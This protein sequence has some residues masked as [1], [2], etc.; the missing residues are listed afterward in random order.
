[1]RTI[2]YFSQNIDKSIFKYINSNLLI[3]ETHHL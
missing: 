1:M 3:V 2:I